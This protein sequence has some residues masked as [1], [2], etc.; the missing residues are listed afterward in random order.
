MYLFVDKYALWTCDPQNK[1]DLAAGSITGL[2]G[3]KVII[4]KKPC[5]EV[6]N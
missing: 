5:Y 1:Q 6:N 3:K 2:K 4:R